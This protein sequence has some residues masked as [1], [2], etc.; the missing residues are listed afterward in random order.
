MPEDQAKHPSSPETAPPA[1]RSPQSRPPAAL[2]AVAA[3]GDSAAL[4]RKPAEPGQLLS[5]VDELKLQVSGLESTLEHQERL[6][7][8][9]TLIG[10]ISHEFNNILTPVSAYAQLALGNLA[11]EELTTKALQRAVE[12][13]ERAAA[14]STAILGFVRDDSA[15][16]GPSSRTAKG[17]VPHGTPAATPRT[18][19]RVVIEDALSCLARDPK[20]DGIRVEVQVDDHVAAA[21]RSLVLQHVLLNVLLNARTAM[22]PGGGQLTLRAEVRQDLPNLGAPDSVSSWEA[23]PTPPRAPASGW[24]VVTIQDSGR[25]MDA[26]Q[27]ANLFRPFYT[28]SGS[29]SGEQDRRHSRAVPRG[30]RGGVVEKWPSPPEGIPERRGTGLGMTICKRLL[31]ECDGFMLVQ[32]AIGKGTTISVILPAAAAAEGAGDGAGHQDGSRQRAA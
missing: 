5:L 21:V 28:R 11:D 8:L 23:G 25:G 20:K 29:W 31:S 17:D 15:G 2:E 27:L 30:T 32:S 22:L 19:I 14:I 13:V 24:V 16:L 26:A 9:G 7:T 4:A 10:L 1:P 18:N 6:A 12:G 3:S